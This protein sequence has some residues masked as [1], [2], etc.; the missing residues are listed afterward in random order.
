[1]YDSYLPPPQ[2]TEPKNEDTED[3]ENTPV[4]KSKRSSTKRK[5]L[6]SAVALSGLLAYLFTSQPKISPI[7]TQ[8]QTSVSTEA[9]ETKEKASLVKSKEETQDYAALISEINQSKEGALNAIV[10]SREQLVF[11]MANL[12]LEQMKDANKPP[13]YLSA[14]RWWLLKVKEK[15]AQLKARTAKNG[16]TS[17]YKGIKDWNT[18]LLEV[19]AL[20][21]VYDSLIKAGKGEQIQIV[22]N[23]NL[24]LTLSQFIEFSTITSIGD[25][26]V[27]EQ[28]RAQLDT[29]KMV[30]TSNQQA[31]KEYKNAI[32]E[33]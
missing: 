8:K 33:K 24:S 28:L 30:E 9:Q 18:W 3:L 23:P 15:V 17:S 7:N 4:P 14:D 31:V 2:T 5:W 26:Q 22:A 1:M 25:T 11:Q 19:Q 6:I 20:I 16:D 12:F 27:L 13:K 29:H 21:V 32:Q 10:V